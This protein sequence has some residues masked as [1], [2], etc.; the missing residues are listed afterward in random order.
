MSTFV[1]EKELK[2]LITKS[3]LP[4]DGKLVAYLENV[5]IDDVESFSLLCES[6]SEVSKF[7]VEKAGYDPEN[8]KVKV[9]MKK[10]W[11]WARAA[12]AEP[13]GQASAQPSASAAMDD[14]AP[15]NKGVREQV[16]KA[17]VLSW[18]FQMPGFRLAAD[19]MF[20]RVY[21]Q[22]NDK[23]KRLEMVHPEN[24]RLQSAVRTNEL[25][26]TLVSGNNVHEFRREVSEVGAH[27]D[28]GLR[29]NA[30]FSTVCLAMAETPGWFKFCELERFVYRI[31]DLLFRKSGK[32]RTPVGVLLE[33]YMAMFSEIAEELRVRDTR[34]GDILERATWER[35]FTS[36]NGV[37]DG[38][39][40][41]KERSR[42]PRRGADDARGA[43]SQIKETL[44]LQKVMQGKLDAQAAELKKLKEQNGNN[45]VT[46]RGNKGG[47]DR[48]GKG[49]KGG[50]GGNRQVTD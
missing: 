20:N 37:H 5:G 24:V 32:Q 1:I 35:H 46:P 22:L 13:T 6:E 21:R 29:I 3:G 16:D 14:E 28:L 7:I 48:G 10:I 15:L 43:D 25:K 49:G 26:G 39:S 31:F 8:V 34:M 50:K 17:W 38:N 11:R 42:S 12:Y 47:K 27:H 9:S 36:W 30:I 4:D 40:H 18:G 2:A 44:K 23:P 41:G 19:N 33:G 45:A